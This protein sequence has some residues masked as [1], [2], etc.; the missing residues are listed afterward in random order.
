MVF[1]F[2]DEAVEN[3]SEVSQACISHVCSCQLMFLAGKAGFTLEVLLFL[4]LKLKYLLN[5][6]TPLKV[7]YIESYLYGFN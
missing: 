5:Q 1:F 2:P 6:M 3:G 7:Y 4:A